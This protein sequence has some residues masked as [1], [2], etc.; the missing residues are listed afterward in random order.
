MKRAVRAEEQLVKEC[1]MKACLSRLEQESVKYAGYSEFMEQVFS[2][3]E[4]L[5]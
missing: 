4:G 2:N 3:V 5:Y 1:V